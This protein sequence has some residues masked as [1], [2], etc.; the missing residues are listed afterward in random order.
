MFGRDRDAH[1]YGIADVE[2]LWHRSRWWRREDAVVGLLDVPGSQLPVGYAITAR[3]HG[4]TLDLL[5]DLADADLLPAAVVVTGP[6]GLGERLAGRYRARWTRDYLKMALPPAAMIPAPDPRV[7]TL[8]PTDLPG[9]HALYDTDAAAGD[10][11]HPGLLATGCYLGV[12]VAG[13]L[14]ASAGVHVL[15]RVN[16]VAAIGNVATAP[17]HRGRGLGRLVT[18]A[19]CDR[20][21]REVP[22]I[23]LNVA[24]DNP[25]ARRLYRR[26]GFVEVLP[27]E[28][29]ELVPA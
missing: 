16:G 18:S 20:L 14:V 22:T 23:G 27:F 13:E 11:F 7:R 29:A 17:S 28:E 8:A 3:A 5:H 10:F 9:L 2:Q 25:A 15:D 1:P 24:V 4:A 19:L 21:R 12:E 26:L 6:P